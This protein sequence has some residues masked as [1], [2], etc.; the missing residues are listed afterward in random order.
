MEAE[1]LF[2]PLNTRQINDANSKI[3]IHFDIE[4]EISNSSYLDD[5]GATWYCATV[6]Y[7]ISRLNRHEIEW[8]AMSKPCEWL[9]IWSVTN[10]WVWWNGLCGLEYVRCVHFSFFVIF[11]QDFCSFFKF[12]ISFFNFKCFFSKTNTKS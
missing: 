4:N 3:F 7:E 8:N 6:H 1:N 11:V 2:Y 10:C 9:T 12:F 5:E